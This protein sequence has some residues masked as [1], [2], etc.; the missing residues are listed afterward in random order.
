MHKTHLPGAKAP[1]CFAAASLMN[2]IEFT[3]LTSDFNIVR[4]FFQNRQQNKFG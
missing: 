3:V 4:L 1:A 2:K